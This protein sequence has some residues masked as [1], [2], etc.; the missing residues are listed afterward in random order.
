MK[1]FNID[2]LQTKLKLI[3]IDKSSDMPILIVDRANLLE[4]FQILYRDPDYKFQFLTT[5]CGIHYPDANPP[6]LGVV[7]HLHSLTQNIRLRI[8]SFTPVEN[9][10]FA[11]LTPLFSTA[12]WME[13]ETY[14]FFGIQFEGHPDLK[15]ILNMDDMD[16]FPL[17]KEYPLEDTTRLD[18]QDSYFG[19]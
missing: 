6:V 17:R 13:R 19:R 16:Y 7:Y 3:R 10:V 5:L 12:N 11:S 18:K 2:A 4:T 15:R 8:K 9:P 1:P 14:D